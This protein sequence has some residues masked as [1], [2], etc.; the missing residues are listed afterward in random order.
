MKHLTLAFTFS[1]I[2]LASRPVQSHNLFTGDVKLACEAVLC[3]SSGTRP[4]QCTPSLQRYFSIKMRTLSETLTARRN[5]LNLCPL[6]SCKTNEV[7]SGESIINDGNK[8][9]DQIKKDATS[10]NH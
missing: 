8:K 9:E 1:T 10:H 4:S 6:T 7:K 3:L 2:L 5:F